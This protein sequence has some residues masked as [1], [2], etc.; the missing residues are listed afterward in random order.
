MSKLSAANR[1]IVRLKYRR[2]FDRLFNVTEEEEDWSFVLA[3][4]HDRTTTSRRIIIV[5][6]RE[7][8][9][10]GQVLRLKANRPGVKSTASYSTSYAANVNVRKLRV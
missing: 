10:R 9:R 2:R 7:Y 8:Q 5:H 6:F 3:S 4:L 1:E